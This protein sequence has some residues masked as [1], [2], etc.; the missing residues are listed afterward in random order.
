M[1]TQSAQPDQGDPADVVAS[2]VE[3]AMAD[4]DG[5][6][7]STTKLEQMAWANGW[8]KEQ[9][10]KAADWSV[11]GDMALSKPQD[12]PPKEQ[13][14]AASTQPSTA[15]TVTVGSKWMFAKR[16]KDGERLKDAK[17]QPF[18]PNQVEV[19]TVDESAKTCTVKTTKDGKNVVDIRSKQPVA[20]KF[21]W[22]EP[23]A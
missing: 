5:A 20:V 22:L 10:G 9:T 23:V 1:T 8:S 18:P 15:M 16:T 19:V 14:A 17:G 11:V 2:L 13:P 12:F 21:E 3:T 7:E 4:P 6:V